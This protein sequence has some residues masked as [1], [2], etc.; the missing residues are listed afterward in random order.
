MDE[1]NKTGSEKYSKTPTGCIQLVFLNRDCDKMHGVFR[2]KE[3]G[4][5]GTGGT[6]RETSGEKQGKI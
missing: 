5:F 1:Q 2:I 6:T 3:V 4:R